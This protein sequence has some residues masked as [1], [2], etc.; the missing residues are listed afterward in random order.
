MTET[1]IPQVIYTE[2][3]VSTVLPFVCHSTRAS[4]PNKYYLFF[5]PQVNQKFGMIYDQPNVEALSSAVFEDDSNYQN[6]PFRHLEGWYIKNLKTNKILPLPENY[7]FSSKAYRDAVLIGWLKPR[8]QR[9]QEQHPLIQCQIKNLDYMMLDRSKLFRGIWVKTKDNGALY[10]LHRPADQHQN[11]KFRCQLAVLSNVFDFCSS[12][13]LPGLSVNELHAKLTK[14]LGHEPFD[15]QLLAKY[16]N[17][18][19]PHLD[20]WCLLSKK[21]AFFKSVKA[22]KA[23]SKK[24]L[25]Q[26]EIV[27]RCQLS[28]NNS[29][30]VFVIFCVYNVYLL[31]INFFLTHLFVCNILFKKVNIVGVL[32]GQDFSGHLKM[33]P[34]SILVVVLVVTIIR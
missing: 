5:I 34:L 14:D 1:E 31:F 4:S 33:N 16:K 32:L 18:I 10:W 23:P 12:S 26:D 19:L 15:L 17:L 9:D 13:M 20:G 3:E 11:L 27:A 25:S 6:Q 7:S 2:E 21:S 28:E 22:M 8:Q 24:L 30:Y 29:R